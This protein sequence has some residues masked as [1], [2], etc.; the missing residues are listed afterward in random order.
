ME[1]I[2][3]NRKVVQ[4]FKTPSPNRFSKDTP[5]GD[6]QLMKSHNIH[7]KPVRV[8]FIFAFYSLLQWRDSRSQL[9]VFYVQLS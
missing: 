7:V 6:I 1:P 2:V 4:D 9:L 8:L 5:S 3:H